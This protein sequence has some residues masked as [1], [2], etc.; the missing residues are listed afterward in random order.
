MT[1]KIF[2]TVS[3]KPEAISHVEAALRRMI[4]PTRAETG[5]VRYELFCEK[6]GPAPSIFWRPMPMTTRLLPTTNRRTSPNSWQASQT[7]LH[8]KSKSSASQRLTAVAPVGWSLSTSCVNF[9][10]RPRASP[11]ITRLPR[12]YAPLRHPKAPG[13]A[14]TSVRL[15]IPDHAMGLPVLHTLS[16]GTCCRHYPGTATGGKIRP[17]R[18]DSRGGLLSSMAFVRSGGLTAPATMCSRLMRPATG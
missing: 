1:T 13:P 16:L 17:R 2:A 18:W 5:C 6:R 9:E 7:S 15:V 14:L 8:E 3:A 11:G 10:L 12:Y 4:S